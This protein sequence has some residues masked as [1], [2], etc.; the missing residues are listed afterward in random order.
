MRLTSFR[1]INESLPEQVQWMST[2]KHYEILVLMINIFSVVKGVC[3]EFNSEI[4]PTLD[5]LFLNFA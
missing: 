5:Y 2:S 3:L 1:C 4:S